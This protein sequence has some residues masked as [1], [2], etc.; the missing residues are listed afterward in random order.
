IRYAENPPKKY[1]DIC[2]F[3]FECE[4]WESLWEE[5]Y[6]IF[7]I[8]CDRGIRTFRV[9][10][11]HTKPLAFWEWCIARVKERYPQTIFLAEA[12]T[13]PKLV[14]EL[15]KLGFT[16]SY[17]YFA[18]RRFKRELVDYMHELT[19]TEVAESF[20]PN[21]WPTTPDILPDDLWGAPRGAFA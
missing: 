4:A 1:Q 20:R 10:N 19:K 2:P 18:W 21:F 17:T 6:S 11:P 12:F 16:Q 9:D 7:E 15:A 8:W 14:Y 5:L 13:R 3:D